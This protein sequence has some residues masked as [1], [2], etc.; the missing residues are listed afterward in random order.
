MSDAAPSDPEL[1]R[2]I[3]LGSVD[4]C[5]SRQAGRRS[6]VTLTEAGPVVGLAD[7]SVRAVDDG[8]VERYRLGG[9]GSA[10]ALAPFADGVLVGERSRRGAI[11]LV[12]DGEERWRHEAAS[13]IGKPTK[14][15]RFFLPMIVDIAV[16][17]AA[18]VAAR[19]YE[20][21]DDG[22]RFESAVYSITPDGTVAWRYDAD[23]SPIA[24]APVEGG[25][26][27]AYNRCPGDHDDGVVVLDADG[28]ER[29]TWDPTDEAGAAT[30]R[31]G[32]VAAIGD[33]LVVTSHADYRGYRLEDGEAA[34]GVDL[35]TP[36]PDGD[37]VYTYP[38]H[39]AA[40][41]SGIVFVTG[42]T[43]PKEGRETDD[44]HPNEQSAVGYTPDGET[45]WRAAVGGF[46]HAVATDGGRILA[47]IAQHF[48]ERDPSVHGFRLFDTEGGLVASGDH[49]G[50]CTA[51]AIDGDRRA[52]V[53]EPVEYHDDD[54][55]VRGAYALWSA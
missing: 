21:G 16:D 47:P 38:N 6:A 5:G 10:I 3:D 35:G 30:R 20:R 7:G 19:R 42:N 41:D 55:G 13:V 43:F 51:A 33:D 12:V 46:C 22:R 8:G 9:E 53:E 40:D 39:V 25:V 2:R 44:R 17:G 11:R 29:W 27:V 52:L 32:D 37:E 31:V 49:D 4:P 34:W 48:R 24:L 45:R 50:V 23:A 15:T 28:G 14:D 54:C 1:A 36:Q 18:Y 26:A